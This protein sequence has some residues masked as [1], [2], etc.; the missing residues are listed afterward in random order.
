MAFSLGAVA[1]GV[2]ETLDRLLAERR[3]EALARQQQAQQ[4]A[5]Q[6]FRNR[7]LAQQ[8]Q[9]EQMRDARERAADRASTAAQQL[10]ATRTRYINAGKALEERF[11][12]GALVPREIA[13]PVM[14]TYDALTEAG[15]MPMAPLLTA[16]SIPVQRFEA[17][18][19]MGADTPMQMAP[20]T[21]AVTAP[22]PSPTLPT[23]PLRRVSAGA[24]AEPMFTRTPTAKEREE[25]DIDTASQNVFRQAQA[26]TTINN[27]EK[28]IDNLN[29]LLATVG[30]QDSKLL[31]TVE[32][33]L[34]RLIAIQ[35]RKI[36]DTRAAASAAQVNVDAKAA[37]EA[38]ARLSPAEQ[39]T[40]QY[41]ITKTRTPPSQANSKRFVLASAGGTPEFGSQAASLLLDSDKT[42]SERIYMRESMLRQYDMLRDVIQSTPP[43]Q[44]NLLSGTLSEIAKKMGLSTSANVFTQLAALVQM[45]YV[46]QQTGKAATLQEYERIKSVIPTITNAQDL[47]LDQID[48]LMKIATDANN[49]DWSDLAG[50]ESRARLIG[51]SR[52]FMPSRA[53]SGTVTNVQAPKKKG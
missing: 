34:G 11:G 41:V 22:A 9:I 45:S 1:G 37:A 48:T 24:M 8:L 44:Q 46:L 21:G 28:T 26:L 25:Q 4:D 42:R 5:E 13:E 18:V 50:G 35:E 31:K 27:P 53:V 19:T 30:Q 49:A 12:P 40:V 43:E 33:T 36:D 39:A 3:A 29:G 38:M 23:V 52:T 7:Q 47:N 6:A 15:D 17:P 2:G 20:D 10:A 14:G 32:P 51:K 16:S